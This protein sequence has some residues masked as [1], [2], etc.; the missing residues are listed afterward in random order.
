MENYKSKWFELPKHDV[1]NGTITQSIVYLIP[2][3]H[4]YKRIGK[5]RRD[6][7][8][9]KIQTTVIPFP[10]LW[11]D[12]ENRPKFLPQ[13]ASKTARITCGQNQ[14]TGYMKYQ[15]SELHGCLLVKICFY[16]DQWYTYV[17]AR[18]ARNKAR[19]FPEVIH[20]KLH[21]IHLEKAGKLLFE[22]KTSIFFG[23]KKGKHVGLP[24]WQ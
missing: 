20:L 21:Q 2:N 5:S 12:P 11:L 13:K 8:N 19:I 22:H 3:N 6:R 4:M 18:A 17:R 15:A 23:Q 10:L 24:F 9:N 14:S 1:H 7:K 16:H